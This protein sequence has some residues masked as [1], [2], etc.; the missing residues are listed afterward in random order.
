MVPLKAGPSSVGVL[1]IRGLLGHKKRLTDLD[2]NIL[3]LLSGQAATALTSS[4]LYTEKSRKLETMQAFI[5]FIK[6]G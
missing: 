5:E 4:R 2:R 6:K 1:V 3:D